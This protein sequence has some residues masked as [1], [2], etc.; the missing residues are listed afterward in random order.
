M[1]NSKS[2]ALTKSI[3]IALFIV[4]LILPP[5]LVFSQ[6]T[7]K[8]EARYNHN[9]GRD[10]IWSMKTDNAGNTAV[11]GQCEI[12]QWS[13]DFDAITR[14]YDTDGNLLWSK[15]YNGI[16]NFRDGGQSLDIDAAG[17]VYSAI[18][19][20][21]AGSYDIVII[22][23]DAI[24][25]NVVWESRFDNMHDQLGAIKLDNSGNIYVC[26]TTGPSTF[27]SATW[28]YLII[29]FDSNGNLLWFRTYDGPG[30]NI[31][32]AFK[33]AVDNAGNAY[34]TGFSTGA[35][36]GYDYA[37]I[38]YDANGIQQWVKRFSGPGSNQDFGRDIALD[39]SGNVYVTG[40]CVFGG[41]RD[42]ITIKYDND[43]HEIWS[44]SYNGTASGA[45]DA[46]AIKIDN[47]GNIIVTGES[48]GIGSGYDYATIKY[49]ASGNP[50]WVNRYN[51][52][53][54]SD[55]GG[56]AI[57]FDNF[58]NIFVTGYSKV[59]GTEN[60]VTLKYNSAGVEKW[61]ASYDNIGALDIPTGID[62][63]QYE[64]IYISGYSYGAGTDYDYVTL[65]YSQD[66]NTKVFC[67]L[68]KIYG[69]GNYKGVFGYKFDHNENI[70][71]GN[72][73]KFIP[74]PE[75]RGQITAF[76]AGTHNNVFTVP[77]GEPS[78]TWHV[79]SGSV[80][81]ECE[82]KGKPVYVECTDHRA[83]MP[84]LNQET[85]YEI[86]YK[87]AGGGDTYDNLELTCEIPD[88][89]DFVSATGSAKMICAGLT[90]NKYKWTR[91]LPL[92]PP[93][94]E[95]IVK[96]KVKVTDITKPD[97]TATCEL[98]FKCGDEFYKSIGCDVN[99]APSGG[100]G[101]GIESNY[102]LAYLLYQRHY[103]ISKGLTTP[104][105]ANQDFVFTPYLLKNL[106]PLNGP[107]N[108]IAVETTP[109][110]ILGISNA[111]SAYAVDYMTGGTR[112]GA[113][114]ATTT[115]PPEVYSHEKAVCDRLAG[116]KL[117][118]LD[119]T[120]VDGHQFYAG[121]FIH[122]I[123]KLSEEAISFS[124]Y[125]TANGFIIENKW[126]IPEY[127]VPPQATNVYNFQVW[128]TD[129]GN[130]RE[131]VNGIIGILKSLK[132]VSYKDDVLINPDVYITTSKYSNNG[133]T[134]LN[135][136]NT[137]NTEKAVTLK[138]EVIKQMGLPEE[139]SYMNLILQPGINIPT[140]EPGFYSNATI[141]MTSQSG[142]KDVVFTASGM[143]GGFAGQ[144]STI[145]RFEYITAPIIT[146]IPP[147]SFYFT[148]GARLKGKLRDVLTIGRSLDGSFD[149]VDLSNFRTLRFESSGIQKLT[150]FF[151]TKQG[152]GYIYPY[153]V[154]NAGN[155]NY[156]NLR[157]VKI[158][159]VSA[160]LTQVTQIGF[161]YDK[162]FN[163]NI[164]DADFSIKNVMIY[165]TDDIS[166][167][168]NPVEYNLS[169][170]YPN[171]FN[172]STTIEVSI[173]KETKVMV[174]VYDILGREVAEILNEVM[175]PVNGYKVTFNASSLPAGLYFY[176]MT[177]GDY[178]QT[179]KMVLIK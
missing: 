44:A 100:G 60:I 12:L 151:E 168:E 179:R 148:G 117:S 66:E 90:G 64:N 165:G 58:N 141:R 81:T 88:G 61:A 26:G 36:T 142:F 167:T 22:K 95:D 79:K 132:P 176:T 87:K 174:K 57:T 14:R 154:I 4:L 111:T 70:P 56:T 23:Y 94:E 76:S 20:Y 155:I 105:I 47:T 93:D 72:D 39:N 175:Q 69:P 50:L 107:M 114:F 125:E 21:G 122:P 11:T 48:Q 126:T 109:F 35:G 128:A 102:N 98:D 37:T 5:S 112:L 9:N 124:V 92:G 119:I 131:I 129:A 41:N 30:S 54:N 144:Q 101:G 140:I 139:I 118:N 120:I 34:I 16:G 33:I 24:T 18:Y 53:G 177:A 8:W 158:N 161:Q 89:C 103:L 147:N 62:I 38:K 91:A 86:K 153:I 97:Y 146:Q 49:D 7:Q 45:D 136:I 134:N 15:T 130:T 73:N 1:K 127:T 96:I 149:G 104:L 25:G 80:T 2:F 156:I 135:I 63:D 77:F 121:R 113:V 143:F 108:S 51:G 171:P 163:P 40:S 82:S 150:V 169:Q 145:E 99:G 162:N 42:Y 74:D 133:L 55:D 160:D 19:S 157:D 13:N 85:E 159:G 78:I 6:I 17:N 106:I 65:K 170:N 138:F 28:D 32:Q 52:L 43:G 75:N 166:G 84:D 110:D 172:P 59:A 10:Y 71:V 29:K 123:R 137:T 3:I 46:K 83:N 173:P 67:N 115:N 27:N 178:R 68:T 164:T 116:Y 152:N 31:D